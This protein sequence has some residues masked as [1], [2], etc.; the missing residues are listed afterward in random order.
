MWTRIKVVT[1][2]RGGCLVEDLEVDGKL[3]RKSWDAKAL[4]GLKWL[5]IGTNVRVLY[6]C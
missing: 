1:V 2:L 6:T 5:R 3:I 4:I